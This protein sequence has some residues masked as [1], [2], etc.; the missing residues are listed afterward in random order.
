MVTQIEHDKLFFDSSI[1]DALVLSKALIDVFL[2]DI[3]PLTHRN[4]Y[5]SQPI[6][7][8]YIKKQRGIISKWEFVSQGRSI[9]DATYSPPFRHCHLISM[10]GNVDTDKRKSM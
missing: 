9:I 4:I 10:S 6:H 3:S 2:S 7:G 8:P 5:I 1:S